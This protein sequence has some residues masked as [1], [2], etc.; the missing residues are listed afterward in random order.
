MMFYGN[1]DNYRV[2]NISRRTL[3]WVKTSFAYML[4]RLQKVIKCKKDKSLTYS[5][6][7]KMNMIAF[8]I[9]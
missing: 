6:N 8:S 1:D 7:L 5:K 4:M 9:K 3:F 2:R